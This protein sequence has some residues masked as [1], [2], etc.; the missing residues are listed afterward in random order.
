M[1]ETLTGHGDLAVSGGGTLRL[2]AGNSFVGSVS[3]ADAGTTL[4]IDDGTA[5]GGNGNAVSLGSGAVLQFGAGMPFG[6]NLTVSGTARLVLADGAASTL[7]GKVAGDTLQVSGNGTL[8][9]GGDV[10]RLDEVWATDS[11]ATLALGGATGTGKL[12]VR[13]GAAATLETGSFATVDKLVVGEAATL[14]ITGKS[15]LVVTH[16]LHQAS[17]STGLSQVRVTGEG[18]L[19]LEQRGA[20]QI[21]V[22]S[23]QTLYTGTLAELDGTRLDSYGLNDVIDVI[24]LDAHGTA[25][26]GVVAKYDPATGK[27]V[28]QLVDGTQSATLAV[29]EGL[30]AGSFA[31]R[32]D[33]A[34]GSFVSFTT[35]LGDQSSAALGATAVRQATGLTGRGVVI[36]VISDSFDA[37]GGLAQDKLN[38][39][40][41]R[42][43]GALP[44]LDGT[45]SDGLEPALGR[46]VVGREY[47]LHPKSW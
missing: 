43:A 38:G 2:S 18:S 34:H 9:L 16:G 28:L 25:H 27:L 12:V 6:H 45:G 37:L 41:N 24:D 20:K 47:R 44:E 33:G 35:P 17:G 13:L 31:V 39:L 42:D 1:A 15:R 5:L 22:Q 10:S 29:P 32:T 26:G 11:Q 30:T 8:S 23:G 36:G 7:S 14:K 3:V 19:V 40:L 4:A 21:T 46:K